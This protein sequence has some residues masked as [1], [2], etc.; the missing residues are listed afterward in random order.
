MLEWNEG[1]SQWDRTTHQVD[2]F[3]DAG[4]RGVL[5]GKTLEVDVAGA[6]LETVGT[7]DL[8][9]K[10]D[11]HFGLGNSNELTLDVELLLDQ[12]SSSRHSLATSSPSAKLL[13]FSVV[14]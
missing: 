12:D 2:V 5:F 8:L 1:T 14:G 13:L 6:G 11:C 7:C 9:I 10:K 3:A 4:V